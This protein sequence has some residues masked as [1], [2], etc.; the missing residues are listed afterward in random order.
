MKAYS[1]QAAMQLSV[2]LH[3]PYNLVTLMYSQALPLLDLVACLFL[4]ARWMLVL[5]V[6]LWSALGPVC[7][8]RQVTLQSLLV[9][10]ASVEQ[11]L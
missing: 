11:L 10:V 5:A 9:L 8:V 3:P 7:A 6:T 1:E 4:P 2:A